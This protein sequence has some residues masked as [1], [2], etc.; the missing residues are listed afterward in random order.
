MKIN[1]AQARDVGFLILAFAIGCL[2]LWGYSHHSP[3]AGLLKN[4]GQQ[5]VEGRKRLEDLSTKEIP[6]KKEY[7]FKLSS[8]HQSFQKFAE[9]SDELSQMFPH[10]ERLGELLDMLSQAAESDGAK[11]LRIKP[12]E[13]KDQGDWWEIPVQMEFRCCLPDLQTYLVSLESMPR[14]IRI[15]SFDITLLED[16]PPQLETKITCSAFVFKKGVFQN[17]T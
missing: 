13:P 7:L 12:G 6:E 15:N 8:L 5:A 14:F 16:I 11:V 2:S 4:L 9:L 3:S 1:K 10:E 17:E